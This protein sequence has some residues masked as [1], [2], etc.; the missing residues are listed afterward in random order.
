MFSDL[1]VFVLDWRLDGGEGKYPPE[2]RMRDYLD[3]RGWRAE[4]GGKVSIRTVQEM[5]RHMD[6]ELDALPTAGQERVARSDGVFLPGTETM[7]VGYSPEYWMEFREA[8]MA[9]WTPAF[10]TQDNSG[11]SNPSDDG[12]E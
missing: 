12:D 10:R 8:V 1:I 5:L 9:G 11:G 2:A 4:R 3:Q 6:P 7:C